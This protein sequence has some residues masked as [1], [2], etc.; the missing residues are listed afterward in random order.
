METLPYLTLDR[1][2][3]R[4]TLD[5][6]EP[7][8]V[9]NSYAAYEVLHATCPVF[10]WEQFGMWCMAGFEDVNRT[11]RDRRFGRERPGGYM[12]SVRAKGDRSHLMDFDRA[13]AGS[14]LELEP[15]VHTR[16]RALVNRAFVSRQVEKLR[17]R[18]EAL[19]HALI[20]GFEADRRADLIPA[21]ATP[22]PATIIAEMMGVPAETGP[23]LVAWSNDMVRMYMHAPTRAVEEQANASARAFSEFISFH[24]DERRRAPGDD[25]LSVL[26]AAREDG[27][28]LSEDELVSSAILLLNAGHEATVHQTGNAVRTILEQG[29]DPSRFFASDE[30]TASTVEECLR[31]D[32]PLHMF[33][34]HAYEAVEIA[35]GVVLQP[36]EQVALL[37][38]AANT[39]PA[40]F[41]APL[42]F[43]PGRE[44]QKTVT[45]GAGIHFCIGAP[46][47][48][49]ELQAALK[50]LFARLPGLRLAEEP[51]YR[52][53]YH[54]HGLERLMVEW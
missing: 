3:R 13:E 21:F 9:Q 45:F 51:R 40:A 38:G 28:K 26:I 31:F 34:R 23:Q 41:D 29:G 25:L 16:L 47:A 17:P 10:F 50:V 53:I 32:A 35:P 24:A 36:G 20:D 11:L 5:P 37:L 42:T 7:A 18:A 43:L 19:A 44:D 12:A 15:P 8:F 14:M 39:D 27:E 1:A 6:H 33:T 4:L 54:F 22:I 2:T 48:R 30:M 46:L 49:L 52:D